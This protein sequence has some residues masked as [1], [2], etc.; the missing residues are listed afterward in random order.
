MKNKIIFHSILSDIFSS[1]IDE[2]R[3]LGYGFKKAE[4]ML[5]RF[6][7]FLQTHQH[8]EISLPKDLVIE[9]CRQSPNETISNRTRRISLLRGLA[10]YMNRI[11]YTAYSFPRGMVT[12]D[13]YAFQPYI[14]SD[15]EIRRMLI[16]CDNYPPSV[17]SPYRH[18]IIPLIIR[19]LYSC[20]LRVSE[21]VGLKKDDVDLTNGTIFIKHTKFNQQRLIPMA[22]S[23]LQ[24]CRAY[25]DHVVM[26]NPDNEFFFPSPYGGQLDTKTVY[27]WFRDI[28]WEA[29]IS[30]TGK[31]PRL[32]DFRHVYAIVTSHFIR[33]IESF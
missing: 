16:A 18:K 17:Y 20:G 28:L 13:R 24:R 1:Y 10:E 8:S 21:A 12:I 33:R 4:S 7:V 6:D 23:L 29:G 11:G 15:E 31:G 26:A 2:K 19:V 25:Y 14:F 27:D 22:D 32:H 5:K 9:W 3:A 30:H